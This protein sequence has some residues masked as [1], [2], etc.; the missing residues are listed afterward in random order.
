VCCEI[1]APGPMLRLLW[2]DVDRDEHEE[3][4]LELCAFVLFHNAAASVTFFSIIIL[5]FQKIGEVDSLHLG[6]VA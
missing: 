5:S 3:N 1:L 4:Q 2:K 6:V